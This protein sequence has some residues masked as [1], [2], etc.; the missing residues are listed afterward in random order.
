MVSVDALLFLAVALVF[1]KPE[2]RLKVVLMI[3]LAHWMYGTL[4]LVIMLL[5]GVFSSLAHISTWFMIVVS[6]VLGL[7]FI[8]KGLQD[9]EGGD[10]HE[11]HGVILNESL[12]S[13]ASLMLYHN[14]SVDEFFS[15][16]QKVQWMAA[17][18]WDGWVMFAN[19]VASMVILLLILVVGSKLIMSSEAF[20]AWVTRNGELS[21]F[22]VFS[23]IMYYM[24]RGIVQNGFGHHPDEIPFTGIAYKLLFVGFALTY[25]YRAFLQTGRGKVWGEKF[26]SMI[27]G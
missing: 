22:F 9:E 20:V 26:G 5:G 3:V 27:P 10:D 13:A 1:V 7:G 17:Q 25:A 24:V 11:A 21:M 8:T 12:I 2:R 15:V 4:G 23:F 16:M 14:V 6:S 19:I 18:G